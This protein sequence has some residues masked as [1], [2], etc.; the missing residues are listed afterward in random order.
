[1]LPS[2]II[3]GTLPA[4]Y[5]SEQ[6]GGAIIKVPFAMS[7]AVNKSEIQGF[8]LK[9]KHIQGGDIIV[10][11]DAHSIDLNNCIVEFKLTKETLESKK[12]IEGTFYKAQLA[13]CYK[14][15]G[16][17]QLGT[18]YFSTVAIIKYT[19][20]PEVSI[21]GLKKSFNNPH[22]YEYTGEYSQFGKDVTEKEYSY[23]FEVKDVDGNVIA[24][25]GYIVHNN[26]TDID[27][28]ESKDTFLFSRDLDEDKKYTI[29]YYVKTNNGLE[30]PSPTYK[31][32]AKKAVV[33]SLNAK[34]V[35][36]LNY[37]NGYVAIT[38][39]GEKNSLNVE[40]VV[41]GSFILSRSSEESN[42]T[43]W[44][45][46]DR[47]ILA[48]ERPSSKKWKDFTIKQ[49]VNYRYSIQQ[50]N[51]ENLYSERILSVVFDEKQQK[52]R[53]LPIYADFEDSFLYD[54]K[55]QLKIKFN[56]KVTSFKKDLLEAKVDTIGSKYPFIFKN[57]R[58]EYREFP[59]SGLISYLMDEEALFS[60]T[61]EQF[62]ERDERVE[63]TIYNIFEW[64]T[65]KDH[66]YQNK[67]REQQYKKNYM[68]F[69]IYDSSKKVYRRWV[70]YL[71]YK[72]DYNPHRDIVL[73]RDYSNF[74]EYYNASQ[75][76]YIRSKKVEYPSNLINP[77]LKTT[78]EVSYNI[79]LER[80]FK[81]EVLEWLTNGEP[82]LFKSPNE[83]NYLV[84][85]MNTSLA[86]NDQ[87]GRMLHTF[88]STAYEVADISYE[89][90]VK[91]G[92]IN[93]SASDAKKIL[94]IASIPLSTT[95]ENYVKL[96]PHIKYVRF[97]DG[98][99]YAQ[100]PLLAVGQVAEWLDI[101]DMKP[102]DQV[103]L[104][105]DLIV[106]GNT[107][108]YSA[109]INVEQIIIPNYMRSTGLVTFGYYGTLNDT[110]SQITGTDIKEKI[111]DQYIGEHQDLIS[112]IENV[113]R[114][115]TTFYD[116]RIYKRPEV[117]LQ[118]VENKLYSSIGN[119]VA[120]LNSNDLITFNKFDYFNP[121]LTYKYTKS[122][123]D[124]VGE[125]YCKVK[126]E[127]T[128]WMDDGKAP[129]KMYKFLDDKARAYEAIRHDTERTVTNPYLMHKKR[130]FDL[131]VK[132]NKLY[133]YNKNDDEFKVYDSF[134]YQD[135]IDYYIKEDIEFIVDPNNP[136]QR[137]L[138]RHSYQKFKDMYE[139]IM[140][141]SSA[142]FR[143]IFKPYECYATIDNQVI[144]VTNTQMYETHNI[145]KVDLIQT[146]VGVY[147]DLF[148]QEQN[149]EYDISKNASL[150]DKKAL[151]DS[152][153][154]KMQSDY[155]IEQCIKNGLR[156][157]YIAEMKTIYEDYDRAYNDYIKALEDYLIQLEEEG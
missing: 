7:R 126:F 139:K 68:F 97:E 96:N 16:K 63:S 34:V 17:S 144:D 27:P 109:P 75:V 35:T 46:L 59:I 113:A 152:Y 82:K 11:L 73:T 44:E 92:I 138:S 87:V 8:R 9:M 131:L 156:T 80:E 31:L 149:I 103:Q 49:G 83:G 51:S 141:K 146:K 77:K 67:L 140:Q 132:A 137:Y 50:Y 145:G 136:Q 5:Y 118:L 70:E 116:I 71:E 66:V 148:Y 74:I 33:S 106:I 91:Y 79:Q 72:D 29:T 130:D 48:F 100:G 40:K 120:T 1:M 41:K 4:F 119:V 20:K 105:G 53:E 38:L 94:K 101:S 52:Y 81:L 114:K 128:D 153:N 26:S 127:N 45:E 18:G 115:V 142:N 30:E 125:L 43:Q 143:A 124:L 111:G 42:Y 110:F 23:R 60:D 123:S 2:P 93:I 28:Y 12:F 78:N 55:R 47:F 62:M 122:K 151:V 21:L 10:T 86:P 84:R 32:M 157:A 88:T 3:E 85:L 6:D 135:S 133:T 76:Y 117:E 98:A 39:D 121:L 15:A 69:Y 61:K 95:D 65:D 150:Q 36:S 24:D 104:N 89:S 102:G 25:T 107:G 134:N 37:E 19:T 99:Y 58:V 147:C 155:L 22:V 54:G 129:D 154:E 57:G 108:T 14:E 13:Y 64:P 56:P 112:E 90:L